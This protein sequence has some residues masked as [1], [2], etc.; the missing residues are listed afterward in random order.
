MLFDFFDTEQLVRRVDEALSN[1]DR[2]KPLREAARRTVLERYDLHRVCLPKQLDL[3]RCLAEGRLPD[4][5]AAPSRPS[6]SAV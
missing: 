1:L 3:V 2:L 4:E 5:A 6:L